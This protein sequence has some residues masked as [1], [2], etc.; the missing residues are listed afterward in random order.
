VTHFAI[1]DAATL[2]NMLAYGALDTAKA[3]ND[4]DTAEFADAALKIT[5]D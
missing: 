2:G 3:V 4:G 1:F 5:L